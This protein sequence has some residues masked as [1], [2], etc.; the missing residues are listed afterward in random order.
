M[1]FEYHYTNL[2]IYE[3]AVGE[4]YRDPDAIKR[5]YYTLP[6][7]EDGGN[8]RHQTPLSAVRVDVTIKW[9][10]AAQE[11]LDTFLKCDTDVM[12]SI[13][14]LIYTRVGVAMM[15]LLKIYFSVR[16]GGLGEFITT[17]AIKVE[18]Y[19]DAMTNSLTEASGGGK[20][21]IPSRW[22]YVIA[23][24]ARSWYD[25]FQQ[26]HMQKEAELAAPINTS[27]STTQPPASFANPTLFD[28]ASALP[29]PA[30][31]YGMS[32]DV[33]QVSGYQTM[34]GS[35]GTPAGMTPT[36]S[37]D[38][39]GSHLNFSGVNQFS[40]YAPPL[41][42]SQYAYEASQ[43]RVIPG[44]TLQNST[45]MPPNTGMELEGW[46]PDGSI[47]GMPSLPEL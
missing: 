1:T 4:G 32:V 29:Q 35:Y 5:Q 28:P 20:Y 2:A 7:P 16:S 18:M 23:I 17:Q 38:Q 47:L 12:R 9:M 24:K 14:N 25:R 21:R 46:V 30:G 31:A 36:W 27:P 34:G 44:G 13:P 10:N 39:G 40:T 11:T 15:S 45:P 42:P 6:R 26:R 43:P 3:L 33:S 37:P 41:V 22:L 19:L 8:E